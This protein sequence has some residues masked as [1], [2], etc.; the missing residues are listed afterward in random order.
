MKITIKRY[1]PHFKPQYKDFTYE[2]PQN[3]TLLEALEYIKESIDN[4]LTFSKGCRSGVCGSCAVRVNEKEL[5]ACE[6]KI[7]DGDKIEALNFIEPIRDLVVDIKKPLKTLKIAKTYL[8]KPNEISMNEK[9]EKLIRKQSDCILCAACYSS[10][11]VFET[12][13]NFL[14]PFALSRSYRYIADKREENKKEKIEAVISNGIFDCT[15]CGN[16]TVVCPQG[17]D[18]K[19]D[20]LMIQSEALKYGYQNPNLSNFGSFGL[21]F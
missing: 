15:L 19:R 8:S 6:Y 4:T 18:P 3:L 7:E 9:D 10:C 2:I 21:D 11:P 5:L 12:N 17:I 1:H 14:G 20:I 16:C 13:S